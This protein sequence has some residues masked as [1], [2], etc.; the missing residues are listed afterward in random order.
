MSKITKLTPEQAQRVKQVRDET[1]SAVT[2]CVTNRDE[3][4]RAIALIVSPALTKYEVHWVYSTSEGYSLSDSLWASLSDSLWASLSDSLWASLSDS[5]W[6][7]LRAL[8]SVSLRASLRDSLWASLSDSLWDS[9]RASLWASLR[10]SLWDSLSD[11]L[12]AS[13]RASLRDSLSDSFWDSLRDSGWIA[14]YLVAC[15]F[16]GIDDERVARIRAYHALV[17]SCAA[18]WVLP[19]H[20]IVCAAPKSCKVVDGKLVEVEW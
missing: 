16:S 17:T 15:E 8:L 2:S 6:A 9:L 7:S 4:E 18:I 1:F 13:L 20:V 11:S 19:G 12:R 10:D 3:A 14:F 5:L